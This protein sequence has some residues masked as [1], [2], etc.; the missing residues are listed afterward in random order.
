MNE[1]A[2]KHERYRFDSIPVHEA[3]VYGILIVLAGTIP[4]NILFAANLHYFPDLPWASLPITIYMWFFWNYLNGSWSPASTSMQRHVLLKA[5]RISKKV[6]L[7]SILAGGLGIISLVLA[8]KLLNRLIVLPIQQL[9]DLTNVPKSTVIFLLCLSAP[10]A[11]IIEEAAFRGYMQGPIEKR[12]GLAVS[13]LI[14]GT[15]F[16]LVHLDF[17][18]IL[19][20]YYIAVSA[21]YG[22]VTFLTKSILPAIL[23]HTSGN[24]YS[25]FDLW[26]SGQAEW[27]SSIGEHALIW[28]SKADS[29]FWYTTLLFIICSILTILSFKKLSLVSAFET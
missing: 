15:L 23:L 2:T 16:A 12:W 10:V 1:S 9:P 17:Q 5:H 28:Q 26:Y 29:G 19:W 20:P 7:W 18:L 6:W 27:Q 4:R 14:T 22:T 21:I 25:N 3:I 11:G 24:L 13:I 8:L